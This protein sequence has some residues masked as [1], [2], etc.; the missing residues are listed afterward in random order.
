MSSPNGQ[1]EMFRGASLDLSAILPSI[2]SHLRH[3]VHGEEQLTR[4]VARLAF[5]EKSYCDLVD[6]SNHV[7]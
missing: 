7:S 6:L 5:M 2:Y 3:T 4:R 1:G